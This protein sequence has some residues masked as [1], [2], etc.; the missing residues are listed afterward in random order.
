MYQMVN[1]SFVAQG[2]LF[3]SHTFVLYLFP[4]TFLITAYWFVFFKLQV[5]FTN[6]P[7]RTRKAF[8]TTQS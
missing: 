1:W 2:F 8:L 4:F 5:G 6:A 7:A 3:I